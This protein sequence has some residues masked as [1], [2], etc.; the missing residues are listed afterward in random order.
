[1][2]KIDLA[3]ELP[4]RRDIRPLHESD[5]PPVLADDSRQHLI[6]DV[7]LGSEI[8]GCGFGEP[9]ICFTELLEP[10][11]KIM[12]TVAARQIRAHQNFVRV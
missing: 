10:H 4:D 1:M 3:A 5:T 12:E 11:L 7:V 6:N 8:I 2:K 9:Q